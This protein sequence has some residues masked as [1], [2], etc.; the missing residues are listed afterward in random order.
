MKPENDTLRT[1]TMALFLAFVIFCWVDACR[2]EEARGEPVKY[3]AVDKGSYDEVIFSED[4]KLMCAKVHVYNQ[5]TIGLNA[6][7]RKQL[8]KATDRC[9]LKL[10]CLTQ[11]HKVG[12][13]D[14]KAWCAMPLNQKQLFLQGVRWN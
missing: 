5:I 14:Y 11:F 2:T 3:K 4:I 12:P 9:Y 6:N 7:D 13:R 1:V 10:K 8:T